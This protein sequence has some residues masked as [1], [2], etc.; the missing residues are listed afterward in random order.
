MI[1]SFTH[2]A[3]A[4]RQCVAC[5]E[6]YTRH[7]PGNI[8]N[9]ATSQALAQLQQFPQ[10]DMQAIDPQFESS[11]NAAADAAKP[12][13]AG[14][15]GKKD[16]KDKKEKKIKDPNQP[17]RPASAYILYQNAVR[18][19]LQASAADM[20]Y[21]DSMKRAAEMWKDLT[22]AQKKVSFRCTNSALSSYPLP[23]K[24]T[25]WELTCLAVRRHV[26]QVCRGVPA[27]GQ[28]VQGWTGGRTSRPWHCG[29]SIYSFAEPP[30]PS[31]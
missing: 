5:I 27:E 6:D 19:T 1:N 3:N 11:P 22:P 16:K 20:S 10:V 8:S 31:L 23:P 21:K 14:A 26:R 9:T 18:P 25:R 12:A 24:T 29:Q 7:D 15:K 28:S 30:P 17:K 4:M 13:A 2:I